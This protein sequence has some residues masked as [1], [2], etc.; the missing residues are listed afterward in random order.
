MSVFFEP[1]KVSSSSSS[2]TCGISL[3]V[4][5]LLQ[6]LTQLFDPIDNG[7]VMDTFDPFD[8]TKPHAIN[9]HCQAFSFDVIRVTLGRIVDINELPTTIGADVMGAYLFSF[10]SYGYE[11]SCSVG[12]AFLKSSLHI[13]IMQRRIFSSPRQKTEAS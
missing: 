4:G 10:H 5:A 1:T 7:G 9:V 8:T 13:S 3:S 11:L 12:I 6:L 2:P